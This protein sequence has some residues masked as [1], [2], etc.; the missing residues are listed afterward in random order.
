MVLCL[1]YEGEFRSDGKDSKALGV[2][3]DVREEEDGGGVNMDNANVS[4]A[5]HRMQQW[6]RST[7]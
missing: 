6:S 5:F 1:A 2:L 7:S 3:A 4:A